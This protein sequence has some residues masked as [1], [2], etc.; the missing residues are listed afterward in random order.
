MYWGI[1]NSCCSCKLG[2]VS[3]IALFMYYSYEHSQFVFS[4]MIVAENGHKKT[5]G[6]I[7]YY[8]NCIELEGIKLNYVRY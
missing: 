2:A 3:H 4:H 6:Q 7:W 8:E 5:N 1:Y